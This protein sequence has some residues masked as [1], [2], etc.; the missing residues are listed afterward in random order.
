MTE[1]NNRWIWVN[2]RMPADGPAIAALDFI[3]RARFYPTRAA[4]VSAA[5]IDLALRLGWRDERFPQYQDHHAE[6]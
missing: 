1:N 2:V 4:V 5:V 3:K 6:A